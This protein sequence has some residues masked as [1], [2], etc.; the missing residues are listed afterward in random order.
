MY[1]H[2]ITN[3][4]RRVLAGHVPEAA[5]VKPIHIAATAASNSKECLVVASPVAAILDLA[6][7][8]ISTLEGLGA[9]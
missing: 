9:R 5:E 8:T 6:R 2:L 1:G 4:C 3:A 7:L